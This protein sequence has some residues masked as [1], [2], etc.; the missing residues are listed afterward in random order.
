MTLK[1]LQ[2]GGYVTVDETSTL[3]LAITGAHKD[4]AFTFNIDGTL[5][6]DFRNVNRVEGNPPGNTV[7]NIGDGASITIKNHTF[8]SALTLNA[9]LLNAAAAGESGVLTTRA[10]LKLQNVTAGTIEGHF[11]EGWTNVGDGEVTGAMQYKLTTTD[12]GVFVSYMVIPEPATATLSLLALAG[13]AARRR[14]R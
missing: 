14:R 4:N 3:N 6:L 11:G 2:G 12:A 5:D 7:F 8:E 10:L 1:K 13:L 9:T